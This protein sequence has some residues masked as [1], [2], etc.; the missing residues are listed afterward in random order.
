MKKTYAILAVFLVLINTS[1]AEGVNKSSKNYVKVENITF[2]EWKNLLKDMED[3]MELSPKGFLKKV[4]LENL[5]PNDE[6][7]VKDIKK[8]KLQLY[9]EFTTEYIPEDILKKIYDDRAKT[10]LLQPPNILYLAVEEKYLVVALKVGITVSKKFMI[11][12]SKNTSS[13]LRLEGKRKKR[14][15]LL[16]INTLEMFRDGKIFKKSK[17]GAWLVENI[18][19]KYI[20]LI[21]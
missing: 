6:K 21:I 19:A 9:N 20:R 2:N 1:Y 11:Q 14:I 13:A 10:N 15:H 5:N 7:V 12:L 17:K 3:M 8:M 16:K 18:D 4:K